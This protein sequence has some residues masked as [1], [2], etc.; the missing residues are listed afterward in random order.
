MFAD[1]AAA[2]LRHQTIF[3]HPAPVVVPFTTRPALVERRGDVYVV[4]KAH[5]QLDAKVLSSCWCPPELSE[6]EFVPL[7]V[8]IG[9]HS[10][11]LI[12]IAEITDQ[13]H[14]YEIRGGCED[15]R[16][17]IAQEWM[18]KAAHIHICYLPDQPE[19]D[20]LHAGDTLRIGG[21]IVDLVRPDGKPLWRSDTVFGDLTGHCETVLALN[22]EVKSQWGNQ[23]SGKEIKG[24]KLPV[25]RPDFTGA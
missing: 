16:V 21:M 10:A 22:W 1:L 11:S 6:S 5:V 13:Q 17:Y 14:H 3:G 2:I 15:R 24:L 9:W 18:H 23:S 20:G 19:I 12:P 25:F 7:D 8:C 4:A